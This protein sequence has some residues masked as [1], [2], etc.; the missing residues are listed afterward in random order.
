M[1]AAIALVLSLLSGLC[2][3]AAPPGITVIDRLQ[4]PGAAVDL[5]R[6][7]H[8]GLPPDLVLPRV[9][10]CA[11]EMLAGRPIPT[12][13]SAIHVT[14][15]VAASGAV[16]SVDARAHV[17]ERDTDSASAPI[18]PALLACV[19]ERIAAL[20]VQ[21]VPGASAIVLA[22]DYRF[23]AREGGLVVVGRVREHAK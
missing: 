20:R 12:S 22:G 5:A 11:V 6:L 4:K 15:R 9:R 8:P 21:R 2:L 23:L 14:L 1:R 19:R 17:A 18:P 7:T 16:E 3:A 13:G 10:A